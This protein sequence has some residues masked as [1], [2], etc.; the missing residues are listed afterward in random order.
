MAAVKHYA[1][2]LCEAGM[3]VCPTVYPVQKSGAPTFGPEDVP[4]RDFAVLIVQGKAYDRPCTVMESDKLA[5]G[6]LPDQVRVCRVNTEL[7]K[8]LNH[9]ISC[10]VLYKRNLL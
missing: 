10:R 2:L 7:N 4:K 5:Y 1:Q 8:E 3:N 6:N 9:Q